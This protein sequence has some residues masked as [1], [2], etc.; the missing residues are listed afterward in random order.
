LDEGETFISIS[1]KYLH[2]YTHLA[3]KVNEMLKMEEELK[4]YLRAQ[5]EIKERFI[6]I[7]EH[8][9]VKN[10]TEVLRTLINWFWREHQEEFR[11]RLEHLDL[12]RDGVL[13]V[14]RDLKSAIRVQFK[15]GKAVC[16]RCGSGCR[17]IDYALSIP[18][19]QE[20]LREKER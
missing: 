20:I 4:V 3:T 18:E 1:F 16:E 19:V 12:N 13:V 8:L 15:Q 6:R 17:H 7:K 9:G 5:G 11:P 14:D 10:D 2:T